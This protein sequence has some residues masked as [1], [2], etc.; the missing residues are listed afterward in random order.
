MK[1]LRVFNLRLGIQNRS[2]EY[3]FIVTLAITDRFE[4]DT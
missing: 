2:F 3:G 1:T 4:G